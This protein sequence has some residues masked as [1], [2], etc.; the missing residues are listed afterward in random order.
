L[1][2]AQLLQLDDFQN[3]DVVDDTMM[4][5]E[6]NIW[7]KVQL[8]YEKPNKIELPKK[9]AQITKLPKVWLCQRGLQPTLRDFIILIVE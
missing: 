7:L 9:I 6:N 3:F 2:L 5:D 4:N 8:L 1:S